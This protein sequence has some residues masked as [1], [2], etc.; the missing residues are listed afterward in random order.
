MAQGT[1]EVGAVSILLKQHVGVPCVPCVKAGD[2]VKV[3]DM[4]ADVP[5][6][7]LG[8]PLHASIN[9]AVSSVSA[10]SIGLRA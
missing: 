9:G 1:L 5:E 10:E 8:A 6:G 2:T 3:G 7:E 4:I